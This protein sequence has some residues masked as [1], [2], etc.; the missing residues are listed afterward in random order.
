MNFHFIYVRSVVRVWCVHL[1]YYCARQTFIEH[2]N[3]EM[4]EIFLH[5]FKSPCAWSEAG[6][7]PSTEQRVPKD[8]HRATA[9]P[10]IPRL[11]DESST[12]T[13]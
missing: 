9:K 11:L 4:S 1:R 6:A 7:R 5:F 13:F 3:M 2:L 12:T 10:R 8:I